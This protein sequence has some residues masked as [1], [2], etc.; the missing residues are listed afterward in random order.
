M[1]YIEKSDNVE[2]VYYVYYDEKK[3]NICKKIR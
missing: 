2:R 3:F 1:E